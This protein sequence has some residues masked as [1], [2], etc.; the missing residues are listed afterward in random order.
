M[1]NRFSSLHGMMFTS[2]LQDKLSNAVSYDR[3]AGYFSSSILEIAGEAIEKME[4][5]VRIIC[6]SELEAEDIKT[7]QNAERAQ[8]QEWCSFKPEE[9]SDAEPRF[10]K[11]Y[12]LLSSGKLE[13][14]VLPKEKFGLA[15]GK[16]GVIT[17]KDGTKTSFL[18]SANE[19]LSAWTKN[20]E[21]VWED[22]SSEA[23][24]WVEREFETLWNSDYA[25][26][27]SKSVISDIKR[28][29]ERTVYSSVKEWKEDTETDTAASVAVE[30]PVYRSSFGLWPHQKYFVELA[31][32]EHKTVGGA[33]LINADQVGLGKTI[34]LATSAMLMSLY[35]DKPVLAIVP[36]T[37]LKQW[38]DDMKDLLGI[39]SAYWDGKEWIDETDHNYPLSIDQCPRRIGIVSQGII[40]N[41][42]ESCK[43]LQDKLLSVRYACVIVDEAH[44]ARRRNMSEKDN[45]KR[46]KKNRLYEFLSSISSRTHSMLLATATPIQ[47]N[48][49]EAW[50]LLNIL[51]GG[52]EAVLG[53]PGSKWTTLSERQ[54]GLDIVSGKRNITSP[55]DLWDW[56]R[57]PLPHFTGTTD[58]D[59]QR[60]KT[61]WADYMTP[62]KIRCDTLY[63]DLIRRIKNWIS[64][65]CEGEN[66]IQKHNP[67]INHIVRRERQF[68]E[69]TINPQT[70][71]PYLEK[72][73]MKLYGES[74]EESLSLGIYLK[75]AY[76]KAEEFWL[77]H[78]SCGISHF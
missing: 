38:R 37:L 36:K 49:I 63:D 3:I 20:Y 14:K 62:D 66:L 57:N 5:K 67:Y 4:G 46:P 77:N 18:G 15:H 58:T 1:I 31:M 75:E 64:D 48:A 16:A 71:T 11:L 78:I 23:V 42:S 6:N 60:L 43:A 19:T 25:I 55:Y 22:N 51:S 33:R 72:I 44:R 32:R 70:G 73:E 29:S 7:A 30:S 59:D 56:L 45:N 61:I 41:A 2:L 26:K 39:P 28:L 17:F 74:K 40:V 27:L 76:E 53:T 13:V 12:T 21:L 35:D 34:Q 47:M 24:E 10:K 54:N 65:G 68:L 50:D 8:H 52:S 9:I 69:N